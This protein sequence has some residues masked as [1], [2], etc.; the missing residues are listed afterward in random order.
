MRLRRRVVN[1]NTLDHTSMKESCHLQQQ[2]LAPAM[3]PTDTPY[4]QVNRTMPLSHRRGRVFAGVGGRE[5]TPKPIHYFARLSRSMRKATPHV[6]LRDRG[7]GPRPDTVVLVDSDWANAREIDFGLVS[8]VLGVDGWTCRYGSY[9]GS[10][11]INRIISLQSRA[12]TCTGWA[13]HL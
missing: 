5:S 10:Y 7:S 1:R 13:G 8:V 6:V 9:T 4:L 11:M 3:R 2:P 12:S